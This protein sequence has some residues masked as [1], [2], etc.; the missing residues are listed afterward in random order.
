M[1]KK[2]GAPRCRSTAASCAGS[3]PQPAGSA[4]GQKHRSQ[5]S[6]RSAGAQWKK[7]WVFW[8]SNLLV[9]L[10]FPSFSSHTLSPYH[11]SPF[12][13]PFL[14]SPAVHYF[15]CTLPFPLPHRW[16]PFPSPAFSCLSPYQI[17]PS[18]GCRLR[19]FSGDVILNP[20]F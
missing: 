12:F 4:V 6:E 13:S 11:S 3:S 14:C 1:A 8:S 5:K 19:W 9:P 16:T 10:L 7:H 2:P 18:S 20:P 17:S 15:S